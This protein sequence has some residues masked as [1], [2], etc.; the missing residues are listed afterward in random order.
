MLRMIPGLLDCPA[1]RQLDSVQVFL[2]PE[3]PSKGKNRRLEDAPEKAALEQEATGMTAEV[4]AP[5]QKE[6][7]HPLV[8]G[9]NEMIFRH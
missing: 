8:V 5:R 6:R 4:V 1:I 2:Y 3:R 9:L 7:F